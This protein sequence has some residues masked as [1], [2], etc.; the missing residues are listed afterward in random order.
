MSSAGATASWS[1]GFF[2]WRSARIALGSG[3][4]LMNGDC[5][6]PTCTTWRSD[7]SNIASPVVLAKS[8]TMT[9][10]P[11]L[12]AGAWLQATVAIATDNNVT[13]RRCGT[14]R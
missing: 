7:A 4:T 12:I 5:W 3:T 8:V 6:S 2:A 11:S 10:S 9:A 14:A 1:I 13:A